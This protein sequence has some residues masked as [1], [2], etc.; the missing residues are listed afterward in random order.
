MFSI[1]SKL[2][3]END[4]TFLKQSCFKPR[5]SCINQ[6]I[7]LTY[8]IYKGFNDGIGLWGYFFNIFKA[9]D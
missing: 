1:Y 3:L 8:E 7:A 2:S 9:F 5:D 6:H 4:L